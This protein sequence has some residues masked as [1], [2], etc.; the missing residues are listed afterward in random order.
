MIRK[1]SDSNS[2]SNEMDMGKIYCFIKFNEIDNFDA[3]D[4]DSDVGIKQTGS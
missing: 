4:K 1:L 3:N 2:I